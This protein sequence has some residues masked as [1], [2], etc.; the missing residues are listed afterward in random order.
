MKKRVFQG[1]YASLEDASEYV[2]QFAEQAELD[3]RSKYAVQLAVTEAIENI[4]QHAYGG[5][6]RGEIECACAVDHEGLTVILRDWGEPFDPESVPTP[7]FDVALDELDNH[8]AGL[9]LI[10]KSM[11]EIEY[12]QEA[13]GINVLRMRKRR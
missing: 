4:I 11:D 2:A 1:S 3:H 10:K 5:E 12:S 7:D 13:S 9:I 8:G 6:G